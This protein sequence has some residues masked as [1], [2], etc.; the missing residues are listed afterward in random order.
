MKTEATE[1][2]CETMLDCF[3]AQMRAVSLKVVPTA[4]LSRQVAGIRGKSLILNL[5]GSP[6]GATESLRSVISLLG[7]MLDLLDGKTGH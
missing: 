2:V 6:A 7:H 3:G 4:L 1:A 5:P